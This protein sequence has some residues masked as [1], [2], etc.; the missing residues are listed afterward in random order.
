[1][2]IGGIRHK[3]LRQFAET[4]RSRGLPDNLVGRLRKLLAFLAAIETADELYIPP[5]DGAHCLVG[6]RKGTWSLTVSK[7]WR[8]TFRIEPTDGIVD[9]DLEDCH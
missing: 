9:L 7:N 8:M 3:T 1:M 6:D 4:G 2:N 5:N